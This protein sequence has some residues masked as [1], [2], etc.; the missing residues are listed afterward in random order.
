MSAIF[1]VL[2]S[3]VAI[4][5]VW[6]FVA[7]LFQPGQPAEPIDAEPIDDP[8]SRVPAFR[9]GPPRGRSGAMALAEPDND[10]PADCL[11]PHR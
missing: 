10:P 4:L 9:K 7:S 2:F 8:Y 6:R 3:L 1:G 5:L 11:P